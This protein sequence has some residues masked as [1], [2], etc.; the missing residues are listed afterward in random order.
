VSGALSAAVFW[1]GSL[2]LAL[3]PMHE[4]LEA[5]GLSE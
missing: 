1:A 5:A 3:S 2:A 4:A